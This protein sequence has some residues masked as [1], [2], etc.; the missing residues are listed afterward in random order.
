MSPATGDPAAVAVALVVA[1]GAVVLLP[2]GLRLLTAPGLAP[3]ARVWPLLGLAAAAA[4]WLPRGAVAVALASAYLTATLALAGCGLTRALTW[5][6]RGRPGPLT[7][8]V[9]VLTALGTP[10]AGALALVAERAGVEL[11]GFDLAVLALTAPHLHYAGFVA[12]LVAA[13]VHA[14]VGASRWARFGAWTV[15]VGTLLVLGGYFVGDAAELVGTVVLTAGTWAVAALVLSR[16]DALAPRRGAV[17]TALVGSVALLPVTMLLALGWA[18]TRVADLPW[19]SVEAMVLTHGLGNALGLGL[20]GVL[21]WYALRR[22][23]APL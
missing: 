7:T 10:S 19:L 11:F 2:L 6:R 12:A 1:L 9:A 13:L 8:E 20:C 21:A 4:P 15:P 14:E 23:A 22:T 3:L 17:R 5:W 18:V 16:L